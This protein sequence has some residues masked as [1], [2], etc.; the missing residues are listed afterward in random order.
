MLDRSAVGQLS[1]LS[2]KTKWQRLPAGDILRSV[3]PAG[4]HCHFV[5]LDND[6]SCPT[7]DLSNI[8]LSQWS[9]LFDRWAV[10]AA[11]NRALLPLCSNHGWH[12]RKITWGFF[13]VGISGLGLWLDVC[14]LRY[15][16]W[17]LKTRFLGL[18]D[19]KNHMV[20]WVSRRLKPYDP[21]YIPDE[22]MDSLPMP[23]SRSSIAECDKNWTTLW[24][25]T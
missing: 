21:S 16:G 18:P 13:Q 24:T 8:R 1:S 23:L 4:N 17:S 6:K 19:G 14:D 22:Q 5:Q 25:L 7:A 10:A 2:S 9:S 20:P 12:G 15:D 11:E 3:S